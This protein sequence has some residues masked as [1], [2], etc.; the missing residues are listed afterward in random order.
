MDSHGKKACERVSE[1][2]LMAW[3]DGELEGDRQALLT[4][5]ISQCSHCED[6]LVTWQTATS[7]FQR[8]VD[9][10]FG[11]EDPMEH[12]MA[13]RDIRARIDADAQRSL[14]GR[15]QNLWSKIWPEHR[16]AALAFSTA[17]V[18]VLAIASP[19]TGFHGSSE[20]GNTGLQPS[21]E[22]ALVTVESLEFDVNSKAMVYKPNGGS[23]TIIWVEPN[24]EISQ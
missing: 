19:F 22:L 8:H 24:S 7:L 3:M 6:Q 16:H 20:H 2:E 11:E 4:E 5:H 15:L 9:D 14:G 12:L 10:V 21:P 17:A 18:M 23:T 13:L 1:E